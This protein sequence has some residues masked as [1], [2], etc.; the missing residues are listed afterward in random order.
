MSLVISF[1]AKPLGYD[2]DLKRISE[3][4]NYSLM[5]YSVFIMLSQ[6]PLSV[7]RIDL[8]IVTQKETC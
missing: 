6:R 4:R 2:V 3:M 1:K 7:N 5:G 8:N